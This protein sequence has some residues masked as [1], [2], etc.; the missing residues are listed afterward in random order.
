[1]SPQT[2]PYG[3]WKSPLTAELLAS[4][5]ISLHEVA[6]DESSGAIYSV[7]CRPTEDGRHAIVQHLNG[8]SKDVLPKELSAHATV[9]EMGGGSIA[10]RPDGKILFAEEE[11][12][13]I[14]LLDPASV[15]A[16]LIYPA[17]KGIRYADFCTHP[18][19]PQW[20]IAIKEDHREATPETQ[21]THVHNTLVMIDIEAGTETTVAQGDD[22]YSHPKFDPSG[23]YVSWIQ[24]THPDMPWTGTV[25]YLA[26]W[27]H[28]SF[29]NVSRIAGKAQEESIAQP[30]W[31]LDG[32]LYFASDC[33]GYWQLFSFDPRN[34]QL[35]SLAVDNLKNAD[36]AIA[37]WEL[38]S[39]TYISLNERTIVA[40]AIADATSKIVVIDTPT[41]SVRELDLP[42]VDIGYDANGIHRVSPD[43]FAIICSS[44][45][46]PQ[47]LALVSITPSFETTRKVLTSTASFELAPEYVS[48]ATAYTT[49]Q[50]HGPQCDGNV[51]M[52][53]FPPC[54]PNFQ[55]EGD[56]PPP[57]LVY[58]HGGPNDHVTPAFNLEIQYW[59][60]RGFAVCAVNYTG[61]TGF[62]RE[63]R[64]RLSGYWGLVDVG[65][66]VSAVQ[67]LAA[68][69]LIDETR[70]GIYGGS[71][72]GYLTLRALHM[73][74]DVWAAG[75]SFYG[76]SDVRAMQADSYKFESQDVDRLVLSKTAMEDREQELHKRSPC[77]YA[78]DITAPLLLLQGTIDTVVTVAQAR[79]MTDA[80][81]AHGRAAEVVEFEGEGHGWVGEKA[82]LESYT[83]TEEWWKR[84]LT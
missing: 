74:P 13:S 58:V 47:E 57:A 52:F 81:R 26:E 29:K 64:E 8:E 11:S 2:A 53:Y 61:S 72:G 70:V 66:A 60:T 39:S 65:D 17:T 28:G 25:L 20:V 44:P 67:Y 63:Y 68:E 36:F 43:S 46:A 18:V 1:M 4:C 76:I 42:Y 38:G 69:G 35:R 15:Q 51:H 7:E 77:Y 40:A 32:V 75:V 71:A 37:E 21:A 23:K 49:P 24:W 31:G 41:L 33:S 16:S 59:T 73:Y 9:Q 45:H 3:Q 27:D 80:M 14:Y 50:K 5:S 34:D 19:S 30:K 12:C 55:A 48:L 83:R 79:M 84:Y 10:M 6:V 62:G 56:S 22:F 54:N 78:D 82:I